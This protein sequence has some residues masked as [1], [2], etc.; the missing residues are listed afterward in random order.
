MSYWWWG[1]QFLD[2]LPTQCISSTSARAASLKRMYSLIHF[3]TSYVLQIYCVPGAVQRCG[4]GHDDGH[5]MQISSFS[6]LVKI[7][8]RLPIYFGIRTSLSCWP[9]RAPPVLAPDSIPNHTPHHLRQQT[10][11]ILCLTINMSGKKRASESCCLCVLFR[12]SNAT[13]PLRAGLEMLPTS[14]EKLFRTSS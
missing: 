4:G 14:L 13:H 7:S 3:F 1:E 6:A 12:L 10:L 9:F 5:G 8:H 11:W 2:L